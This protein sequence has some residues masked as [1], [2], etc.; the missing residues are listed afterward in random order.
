MNIDAAII[1]G[2]ILI[3]CINMYFLLKDF[4]LFSFFGV[5]MGSILLYKSLLN[6]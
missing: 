5:I 4:E 6:L 1:T 3:I 2:M